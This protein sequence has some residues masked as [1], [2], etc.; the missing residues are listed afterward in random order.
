[1]AADNTQLKKTVTQFRRAMGLLIRNVP[2]TVLNKTGKTAGQKQVSEAVWQELENQIRHRGDSAVCNRELLGEDFLRWAF[3]PKQAHRSPNL[4]IGLTMSWE[5]GRGPAWTTVSIG[6]WGTLRT[7]YT[8]DSPGDH[9]AIDFDDEISFVPAGGAASDVADKLEEWANTGRIA[10]IDVL[11]AQ[12]GRWEG[13]VAGTQYVPLVEG[14]SGRGRGKNQGR[15]GQSQ[16][17]VASDSRGRGFGRMHLLHMLGEIASRKMSGH[18]RYEA[19]A[20]AVSWTANL[21]FENSKM[22]KLLQSLGFESVPVYKAG[23]GERAKEVGGNKVKQYMIIHNVGARAAAN[24]WWE[25]VRSKL[26][27]MPAMCPERTGTGI[28]MCV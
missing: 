2:L 6:S 17:A 10:E 12:G 23:T 26:T 7:K 21:S 5:S 27:E 15:Q 20:V 13:V 16:L 14:G 8:P 25:R 24:K 3:T 1:M 19:V 18:A 28:G 4:S 9:N 11:C 22:K